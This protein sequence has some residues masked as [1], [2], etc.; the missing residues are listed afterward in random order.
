[1]TIETKYLDAIIKHRRNLCRSDLQ[2]ALAEPIFQSYM[3]NWFVL[4]V[5][6]PG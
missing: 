5:G 1:M 6:G 4:S 2:A 3:D